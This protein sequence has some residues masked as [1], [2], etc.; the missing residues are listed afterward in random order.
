MCFLRPAEALKNNA[1]MIQSI[2]SKVPASTTSQKNSSSSIRFAS[3]QAFKKFQNIRQLWSGYF[4]LLAHHLPYTAIQ[5]PIY[6]VL[7]GYFAQSTITR[8]PLL[9]NCQESDKK[10]YQIVTNATNASVSGAI[11]GGI[12]AVLTAP[13]DMVKTRVNLDAPDQSLPQSNRVLNAARSIIATEGL[14]GLFRGCGINIFMGVVGSGV[15]LGLYE[16]S[17]T[18]LSYE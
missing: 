8:Q 12:A 9:H 6:E 5:M 4:A 16:G 3:V 18:W 1:Q 11:A 7:K 14:R 17:K 2:S 13:T 15:W 10:Y